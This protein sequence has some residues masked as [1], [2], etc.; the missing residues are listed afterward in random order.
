VFALALLLIYLVLA[1]QFESFVD[2]FVVLLTMPRALAGALT[3]FEIPGTDAGNCDGTRKR[4]KA[5][6]PGGGDDFVKLPADSDGSRFTG[7]AV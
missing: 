4:L 1:A 7:L 5:C 6:C 3:L 2:R